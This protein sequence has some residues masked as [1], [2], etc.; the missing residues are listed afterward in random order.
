M[1]S[2]RLIQKRKRDTSVSTVGRKRHSRTSS[3]RSKQRPAKATQAPNQ[4]PR[5]LFH[6]PPQP[7]SKVQPCAYDEVQCSED[8][9]AESA[10]DDTEYEVERILASRLFGGNLQYQAQWVGNDVD[11]K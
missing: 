3:K 6:R 1:S 11:P 2:Q 10:S 4:R 8:T 7:T 5:Y 9:G